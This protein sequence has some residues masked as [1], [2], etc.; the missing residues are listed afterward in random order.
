MT[1][2][3]DDRT[4][5]AIIKRKYNMDTKVSSAIIKALKEWAHADESTFINAMKLM[6]AS[7]GHIHVEFLV[8]TCTLDRHG[9]CDFF[10]DDVVDGDPIV[11]AYEK[12]DCWG[13]PDTIYKSHK[14]LNGKE[15][16]EL[17]TAIAEAGPA[18]I[19]KLLPFDDEGLGDPI[20][21]AHKKLREEMDAVDYARF[22]QIFEL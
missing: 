2:K 6:N 12:H 11:Y 15:I 17:K 7:E 8:P 21:Y 9:Y 13:D 18:I 10:I 1:I 16:E 3:D 5:I 4:I 22:R 20:V 19:F 14:I